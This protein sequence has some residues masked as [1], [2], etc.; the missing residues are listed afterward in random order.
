MRYNK[1]LKK[2][3]FCGNLEAFVIKCAIVDANG[4]YA[5]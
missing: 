5:K 4:T 3:L 2:S 1:S